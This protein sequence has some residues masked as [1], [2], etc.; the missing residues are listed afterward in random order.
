MIRV[1]ANPIAAEPYR[2]L[3][4]SAAGR[5]HRRQ[6]GVR[7]R[8]LQQRRRAGALAAMRKEAPGFDPEDGDWHWQW[9]DAPT[10]PSRATTRAARASSCITCHRAAECMARDYMCTVDDTPRGTLHAGARG[11]A[12][13]A[14]CRSPARSPTDVYAV[15]ADASDGAAR[16]V[17]HYD[18][19]SWKRL[20]SGA[21]RRA[22]VDQRH[23]DRRRLLHGRRRRPDPAVRSAEQRQF[24]RHTTPDSTTTLFGIWGTAANNLWAVGGDDREP[25]GALALRRH[26]VDGAG[27]LGGRAAGRAATLYKVWGTRGQR[28]LRGRRDRHHPALRRTRAGRWSP[29][30]TDNA[31]FTVHGDGSSLAAV[32]GFFGQGI[33]LEQNGTGAFARARALGRR[34]AQRRLRAAERRRGRGRRQP[35]RRRAQRVRLGTVDEGS[36]PA[37]R[38]FHARLDRSR[39]RHLGGRRPTLRAQRRRARLRRFAVGAPAV[40][41]Q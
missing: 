7:R 26:D 38:D 37:L 41:V 24:T 15:G 3:R 23:A 28:R 2:Q 11:P 31:L 29:S 5:Q 36:D 14:C 30:T 35:G 10:A 16:Y 22:V 6:G 33:I 9:V 25:G 4:E 18:G 12:G 13:G 32:G 20:D 21:T 27:R 19:S 8:R 34:R 40:R 1:L 17:L 39:R